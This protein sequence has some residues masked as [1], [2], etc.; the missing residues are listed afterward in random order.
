MPL[1]CV[2]LLAC[3]CDGNTKPCLVLLLRLMEIWL[4]IRFNCCFS[5]ESWFLFASMCVV[6]CEMFKMLVSVLESEHFVV[7][8]ME[9]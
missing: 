5:Y 8:V 3:L 7:L 4:L 6:W 1:I 2:Y 9:R